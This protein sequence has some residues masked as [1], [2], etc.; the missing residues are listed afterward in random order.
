M[1]KLLNSHDLSEL[2]AI[3]WWRTTRSGEGR[4]VEYSSTTVASVLSTVMRYSTMP[5]PVSGLRRTAIRLC[6]ST[7][8][9]MEGMVESVCST[10]AEVMTSFPNAEALKNI[11]FW[12]CRLP[13]Y[14]GFDES[15]ITEYG[16]AFFVFSFYVFAD[17]MVNAVMSSSP[18]VRVCFSSLN[19][20]LNGERCNV[21]IA[22][23]PCV[24][25]RMSQSD[26]K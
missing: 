19:G 21:I 11:S 14:F 9:M 15:S 3:Q 13:E 17:W 4:T 10:A 1:M 7:R 12:H 23:C 22:M 16:Y 2:V 20:E 6:V 5:W 25:V 18:C 24:C 26:A 8:S